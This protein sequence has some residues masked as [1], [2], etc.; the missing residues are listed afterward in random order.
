M[1]GTPEA[2]DMVITFVIPGKRRLI[3]ES[4]VFG[5]VATMSSKGA[6]GR[7]KLTH[8]GRCSSIADST[9]HGGTTLDH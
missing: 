1:C 2:P 5:V 6:L 9:G 3:M 7:R 8:A 4:M